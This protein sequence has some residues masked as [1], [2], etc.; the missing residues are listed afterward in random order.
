MYRRFKKNCNSRIA[1]Q[2]TDCTKNE[3][4]PQREFDHANYRRDLETLLKYA[5][6]E[7]RHIGLER[8]RSQL[9]YIRH[10]LWV[11]A[12]IIGT[13]TPLF[14]FIR[15]ALENMT[16]FSPQPTLLF[17]GMCFMTIT[18]A[19]IVFGLGI[20]SLRG[21]DLTHFPFGEFMAHADTAFE[22]AK[23]GMCRPTMLT[24]MINSIDSVNKVHAPR[25]HAVGRKLRLMSYL[26]IGSLICGILAV[27]SRI[28]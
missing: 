22:S 10:Y 8:Q 28:N 12:L 26:L 18:L 14:W 24:T 9:T 20:D 25:L 2:S 5:Y 7:Y 4:F 13:A 17:Y 27:L 3:P 11:A 16:Y 1:R 19:L 15:G 23:S 6:D 21:R